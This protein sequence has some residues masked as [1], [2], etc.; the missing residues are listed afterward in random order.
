MDSI[1][2]RFSRIDILVNAVGG[3]SINSLMTTAGMPPMTIVENSLQI[4]SIWPSV[5]A[6][7][8]LVL[9]GR[10]DANSMVYLDS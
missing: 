9:P 1:V 8:S 6:Y 2:T 5:E 3:N 4:E 10:D 7:L